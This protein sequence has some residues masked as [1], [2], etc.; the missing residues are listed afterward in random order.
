MVSMVGFAWSQGPPADPDTSTYKDSNQLLKEVSNEIPEFGGVF[1]SDEQTVLNVYLTE[2]ENDTQKQA[3]TREKIEELFDVEPGLRLNVIKGN[4][5]ITRLFEWYDLMKSEGIWDEDGVI[6][7]DLQEGS[8]ELYIGVVNEENVEPVYTFLEGISIP[9]GAVTA[10]VIEQPRQHGH[11]VRERAHDNKMAGGYQINFGHGDCTMGFVAIRDGTAGMV[12]A[13]HCTEAQ[14]YD[15]GVTSNNQVHQPSASNLIG[16]E[17]IDP[18]FST[19]LTGCN[20][21]DGCRHSDSAFVDFSSGVQYN[22]GWIA[23]PASYWGISVDPDTA[24]YSITSDSGS[25]V[26]GDKVLKVGRSTG[27]TKGNVTHVCI[28]ADDTT[29][30]EWIGTYLC[31]TQV[32]V[33]SLPGD[34]GSPVFKVLNGDQVKLVGILTHGD[35]Q[36]YQF[37]PLGRIFMDLGLNSTWDVCISGC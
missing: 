17:E 12:T 15:G 2:N 23:K 1:L 7:I 16:F 10:E 32:N 11:T 13:G 21:S 14:P 28:E 27:L 3:D 30:T 26:V 24:H 35:S 34:S 4:Y 8:N 25:A 36:R 18:S 9:R 31:Q 5:T 37:S 19:S 33:R 6:M 20:D 22:R 29:N